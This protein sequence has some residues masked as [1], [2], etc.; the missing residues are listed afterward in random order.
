MITR[1]FTPSKADL[2]LWVY[3]Y[4]NSNHNEQTLKPYTY[5]DTDLCLPFQEKRQVVHS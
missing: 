3:G 2:Y 4:V 1:A 5:Y